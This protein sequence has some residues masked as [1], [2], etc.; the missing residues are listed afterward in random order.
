MSRSTDQLPVS[1]MN[2]GSATPAPS[3]SSASSRKHVLLALERRRE[4]VLATLAPFMPGGEAASSQLARPWHCRDLYEESCLATLITGEARRR[5][6]TAQ[7]DLGSDDERWGRVLLSAY[8]SDLVALSAVRGRLGGRWLGPRAK[9]EAERS[10]QRRFTALLIE[11]DAEQNRA[12]AIS[13]YGPFAGRRHAERSVAVQTLGESSGP[14]SAEAPAPSTAVAR[15]RRPAPGSTRLAE[16]RRPLAIGAVAVLA[17]ILALLAD[18]FA[19]GEASPTLGAAAFTQQAIRGLNTDA[20]VAAAERAEA[21]AEARERA[22]E[23]AAARAA[24]REQARERAAAREAASADTAAEEATPQE[25]TST[26]EPPVEPVEPAAPA[27][28]PAPGPGGP[29]ARRPRPRA[30]AR[31]HR[32]R[33]QLLHLRMLNRARTLP[34]IAI[35][36]LGLGL[37]SAAAGGGYTVAQCDGAVNPSPGQAIQNGRAMPTR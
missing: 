21:R 15:P 31:A 10:A 9:G 12:E 4:T 36:A 25:T 34:L 2:Q 24:A 18:P 37:P 7:F 19:G 8:G 22:R 14:G 30:G 1:S 3:A 33:R 35:V 23:R 32:R 11:L 5:L 6:R 29:G 20:V 16:I 26:A 27:P 28:A 17:L 13:R